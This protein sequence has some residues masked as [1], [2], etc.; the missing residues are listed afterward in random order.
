MRQVILNVPDNKFPFFM[1]LV[2]N[3]DFVK[4]KEVEKEPTK[5]EILQGIAE[6]F[7][8]AKHYRQ[9]KLKLKPAKELLDEL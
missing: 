1:E 9:G 3:L 5:E 2:K 7:Q 4:M 8:Q 6:G